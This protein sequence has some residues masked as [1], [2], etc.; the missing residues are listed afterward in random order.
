MDVGLD[1]DHA[2]RTTEKEAAVDAKNLWSLLAKAIG[3]GAT[4]VQKAE[5]ISNIA[6][7]YDPTT[8]LHDPKLTLSEVASWNAMQ[9]NAIERGTV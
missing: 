5:V 1:Q 3:H 4:L 6:Q 7:E 9:W 2:L 8:G